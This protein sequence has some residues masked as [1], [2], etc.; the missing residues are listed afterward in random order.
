MGRIYTAS[1]ESVAVS[2]AQD[3]FELVAPST[4]TVILHGVVIGQS[5][6]AGDAQ[7]EL[8]PVAIMRGHTTS[9]SGGSTPTARPLNPNGAS[10]SSTIEANN[11]TVATTSGVTV[12]ADTFNVQVG[13]PYIP[14]PENRIVLAPSQRLVVRIPAPADA[15]TLSAT[16]TWEEVS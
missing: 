12:Y 6:D 2:A 10:A 15:L 11:T 1:V 4:S 14:I 9:G 13:W 3:V 5:S 7:A 8:L 16:I